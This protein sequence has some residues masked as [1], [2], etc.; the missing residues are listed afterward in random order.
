M[1]DEITDK[2][3]DCGAKAKATVEITKK[4]KGNDEIFHEELVMCTRCATF[5][6]NYAE[7]MLDSQKRNYTKTVTN[8][9]NET[10]LLLNE[11]EFDK[12]ETV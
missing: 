6:V 8:T 7:R 4:F 11:T 5:L 12:A 2:Q 3:C 9:K 10:T 1:P